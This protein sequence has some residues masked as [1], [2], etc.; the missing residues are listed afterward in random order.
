[1]RLF[2]RYRKKD[3]NLEIGISE[4]EEMK[5]YYNFSYSGAN[6]F[7]ETFA[8]EKTNKQRMEYSFVGGRNSMFTLERNF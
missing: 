8:E 3:I 1:M 6:T 5:K 7:D 4:I 2:R